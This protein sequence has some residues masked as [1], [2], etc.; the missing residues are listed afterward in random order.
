MAKCLAA[1]QV[2]FLVWPLTVVAQPCTPPAQQMMEIMLPGRPGLP[3]GAQIKIQV[4]VTVVPETCAPAPAPTT[5]ALHGPP[6]PH[7]TSV[8]HGEPRL[9]TLAPRNVIRPN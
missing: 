9:P 6:P 8:L 3:P 4:P 7:G 1:A 2:V 5:D